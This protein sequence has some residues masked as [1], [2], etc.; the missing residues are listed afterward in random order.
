[1]S[2]LQP[3]QKDGESGRVCRPGVW[4]PW[5]DGGQ[6]LF[7][8][9][10]PKSIQSLIVCRGSQEHIPT[11][12]NLSDMVWGPDTGHSN[13]GTQAQSHLASRPRSLCSS[14]RRAA[15]TRKQAAWS[16]GRCSCLDPGHSASFTGASICHSTE[17][18]RVARGCE[19]WPCSVAWRKPCLLPGLGFLCCKKGE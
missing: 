16:W 5:P 9:V 2:Q 12:P 18:K 19:F 15:G 10:D 17:Q 1:M 6:C 11:H 8:C 7:L 13:E 3:L 4:A 14:V